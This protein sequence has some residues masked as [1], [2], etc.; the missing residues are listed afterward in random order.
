MQWVLG[1]SGRGGMEE[2]WRARGLPRCREGLD[3]GN[4]GERRVK[5]RWVCGVARG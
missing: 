5:G 1:D 3:A 4:G 2:Q